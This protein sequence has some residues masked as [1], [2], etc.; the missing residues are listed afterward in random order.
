M[1]EIDCGGVEDGVEVLKFRFS[2]EPHFTL[3]LEG[4]KKRYPCKNATNFNMVF[5]VLQ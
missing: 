3:V 5:I 2:L 4:T 1:Y